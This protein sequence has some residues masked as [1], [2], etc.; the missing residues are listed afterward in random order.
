MDGEW[1]LRDDLPQEAND[2]GIVNNIIQT[3]TVP[4]TATGK[5][6]AADIATAKSGDDQEAASAA[7]DIPTP[8]SEPIKALADTTAPPTFVA[9][10]QEFVASKASEPVRIHEVEA[11][12]PL[13]DLAEATAPMPGVTASVITARDVVNAAHEFVDGINGPSPGA[14]PNVELSPEAALPPSRGADV[15]AKGE[16]PSV[17]TLAIDPAV[18]P[19]E[20]ATAETPTPSMTEVP[21]SV[22]NEVAEPAMGTAEAVDTTSIGAVIPPEVKDPVDAAAP[23]PGE[24]SIEGPSLLTTFASNVASN[25]GL[26]LKSLTGIDPI[27]PNKV[28]H[29]DSFPRLECLVF[30]CMTDVFFV[31]LRIF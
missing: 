30:F 3:P 2:V 15:T 22:A 21:H 27:N 6:A 29:F 31:Q 28:N 23:I 9:T 11:S 14:T 12:Q 1:R 5:D 4:E 24:L 16:K 19:T 10:V 8:P 26:A 13:K 20:E 7:T 25:V 18:T 17:S